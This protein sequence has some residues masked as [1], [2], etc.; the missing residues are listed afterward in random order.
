MTE[1]INIWAIEKASAVTLL[2]SKSQV[3]TEELLEEIL[4]N[5]P[6]ML[7]PWS[8]TDWQTDANGRRRIR[9]AWRG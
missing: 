2:E 6:Q 7:L 9:P 4:T 5:N 8:E 1:E 3:D